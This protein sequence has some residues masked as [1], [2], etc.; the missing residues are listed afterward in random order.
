MQA[1]FEYNP[2]GIFMFFVAFSHVLSFFAWYS[3]FIAVRNEIISKGILLFTV[4]GPGLTFILP[5]SNE[6]NPKS[7][8]TYVTKYLLEQSRK[9]GILK[10]ISCYVQYLQEIYSKKFEFL[11]FL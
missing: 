3:W 2:F 6:I 1:L 8:Y 5:A 7:D 9:L 4:T 11:I 10:T